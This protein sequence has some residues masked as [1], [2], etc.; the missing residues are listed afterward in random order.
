VPLTAVVDPAARGNILAKGIAHCSEG[1]R[2]F[3]CAR[4]STPRAYLPSLDRISR[5]VEA[6][7]GGMA[8]ND[9]A[10]DQ[11]LVVGRKGVVEVIVP[12]LFCPGAR[13]DRTDELRVQQPGHRELP[14]GEAFVLRVPLDFLRQFE[15]LRPPLIAGPTGNT[16]VSLSLQ[17]SW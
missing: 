12:L 15:R 8:G 13:N 1:R 14:R 6:W 3:A 5:I 4:G 7:R 9:H 2:V 17:L 10:I 11:R 16:T